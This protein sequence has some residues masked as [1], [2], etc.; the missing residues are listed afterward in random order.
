MPRIFRSLYVQ[1]LI[2]IVLG[3]LVGFLF[4]SFGESLKPLGDGFIKLIKM[5]IA[6]IIFATV[7]SGIA[8]MRDT[9]KVGRVGGKALIYFEVVT[10]FAL[11]IGL[12]IANVLRPGHGMNVNPA[13]LDTSAISKYTQAAGEQSVSDFILNIIPNTLVSA[14]T[15]GDLLQVL[16]I[17]VLFGFALMKL[18]TLGEKVL[19][20]IEAVNNAVFVILGF[21]MRLAPIGAFGAMAFTIGKYGV[22]TLAQLAYLM[23]AFYATCLLFVFVVLGLIAHFA[24][25]SIFK[26]VRFIKE[27]LLLVLGTSSSES[28]LPRL[29]TKLEYAGASRSVVGLVVPAGYSFNLDG[30]SIYLTMATL[31]IAQATNTHLSLGQQLGVLGVLLLTSKGAAGVTGSGFITL[32]ATL[33]AVGHVPVAGLALILGVD[34]FMSEARALTNFVGN[35]VATLVIARS[36]NALDTSRL[37]RVLNGEELPPATPEVAAEERGEGRQLDSPRPA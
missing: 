20:G 6:P 35:G 36:E 31:F 24:G 16:L 22:G 37:Q 15:E 34:R 2:A 14:F 17:A 33:S 18:G 30:T 4:P 32:A 8:H 27:E 13:T 7:V 5:L 26:F 12:V 21:V 10:T 3:I 19:A 28:A 25:F 1:V 11:I 29:I 9:R 23:V